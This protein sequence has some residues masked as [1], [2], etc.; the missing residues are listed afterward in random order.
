M[1]TKGTRLR[2]FTVNEKIK[3][4]KEAEET[5]NRS[6][7]RKFD[8]SE[9]CICDWKKKKKKETASFAEQWHEKGFRGQKAKF[10][11]IEEKLV[12]FIEEKSQIGCAISTEMCQVKAR[13][14]ARN[15]NQFEFKASR[16]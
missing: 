11:E 5:S 13:E 16:G 4:V 14:L 1:S 3:I 8:V 12:Q 2:S 9:S 7:A 15:L 10:P 6:A